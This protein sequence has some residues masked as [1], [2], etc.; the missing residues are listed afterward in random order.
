MTAIAGIKNNNIM[1]HNL[2]WFENN[3]GKTIFRMPTLR[4]DELK[5]IEIK[6]IDKEHSNYLMSSQDE[7]GLVYWGE[8]DKIIM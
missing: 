4:E 5:L 8:Y 6:V 7:L 1:K 3:I 2:K